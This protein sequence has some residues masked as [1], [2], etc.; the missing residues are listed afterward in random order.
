MSRRSAGDKSHRAIQLIVAAVHRRY[1][2]LPRHLRPAIDD[3]RCQPITF[4]ERVALAMWDYYPIPPEVIRGGCT[5]AEYRRRRQLGKTRKVDMPTPEQLVVSLLDHL[6]QNPHHVLALVWGWWFAGI[7][8][9]PWFG[10]P[11]IVL[12]VEEIDVN[13]PPQTEF[14]PHEHYRPGSLNDPNYY[15]RWHHWSLHTN[16]SN[17]LLGA[18]YGLRALLPDHIL[19]LSVEPL[20]ADI[21]P[22]LRQHYPD[23]AH[24]V[25]WVKL[26][27]E[28]NQSRAPARPCPVEWL[29][30]LR[31]HFR[32]GAAAVFIKQLGSQPTANAARLRLRD[33]HGGDWR[34]WPEDLRVREMP[35]PNL[36]RA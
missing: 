34:E 6:R 25:S 16:G 9:W 30:G 2:K 26:G 13:N 12:G 27:G 10:S 8:E 35:T 21:A 32:A 7:G 24:V 33:G 20:L 4:A 18:V 1:T 36:E 29:R 3:P 11:D 17:W 31:D 19:G 14:A 5:R 15:H 23:V 28:S 22:A